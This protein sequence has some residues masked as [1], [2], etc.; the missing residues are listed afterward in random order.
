MTPRT[1]LAARVLTVGA[2]AVV[3]AAAFSGAPA[4]AADPDPDATD[5]TVAVEGTGS[6]VAVAPGQAVTNL[7]VVN[8]RVPGGPS[9]RAGSGTMTFTVT[10]PA[11]TGT[12]VPFS[13]SGNGTRNLA[14]CTGVGTTTVVCTNGNPWDMAPGSGTQYNHIRLPVQVSADALPGDVITIRS[15]LELNSTYN[16]LNPDPT[17][18]S[19]A[20]IP[21]PAA[22]VTSSGTVGP[23]P[24]ITGTG[25]VGAP[26]TTVSVAVAGRA[27][28]TVPVAADGTW[29]LPVTEALPD[30]P[31]SISVVQQRNGFSGPTATG[32]VTVD[33]TAPAAPDADEPGTWDDGTGTLTGT[34]E[35][36]STVI[37]RDADGTELGRAVADPVT[38]AW[39]LPVETAL[40]E[41]RTELT[42]VA[43]DAFGNTSEPTTVVVAVPDTTPPA[44][45]VVTSPP[46]LTNPTGPITGTAEPGSTVVVRD[47][48]GT[49]IGTGVA[50]SSGKWSVTLP[51]L[52]VGDTALTI[53]ATDA[54]GNESAPTTVTVTVA[55]VVPPV[56][57]TP[58]PPTPTPVPTTPSAG[59]GDLAFTG[60]PGLGSTLAVA[61]AMLAVGGVLVIGRR[62]SLRKS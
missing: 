24:T 11:V 47:A 58:V 8:L 21:V 59:A 45:P 18:I 35:P 49:I 2:A 52:P 7:N 62:R 14:G 12:R 10:G 32:S 37:V 36:G 9:V 25:I 1:T 15:A 20:T 38:G 61:G 4:N 46:Q 34:A 19:T 54:A 41:G 27:A 28:V 3:L 56:S 13:V 5:V 57:P 16:N 30:G 6:N 23:T 31:A 53:V 44:P 51:A 17:G 50:D 26:G 43:E 22:S 39:S 55:E 33:A 29:S 42:V 48:N 40:P 60:A